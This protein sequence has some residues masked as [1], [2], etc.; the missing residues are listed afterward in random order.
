MASAGKGEPSEGEAYWLSVIAKGLAYLC[1]NSAEL[2]DAD[3]GTKG[4]LLTSLGLRRK[5][6][7]QILKTTEETVRVSMTKSKR[8][9]RTT[10]GRTKAK[11]S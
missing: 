9:G 5:H 2:K 8:S 1:L 4:D 11:G 6:I 10:H 3:I 7:A